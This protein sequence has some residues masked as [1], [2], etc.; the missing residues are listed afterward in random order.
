MA[1]ITPNK[2]LV[3]CVDLVGGRRKLAP[4]LVVRGASTGND[5]A[6]EFIDYMTA[7]EFRMIREQLGLSLSELARAL[8]ITSVRNVAQFEEGARPVSGPV[9]LIMEH[10]KAGDIKPQI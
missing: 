7:E 8:R 10:L 3:A 2:P 6:T 9:S 4:V 1:V 5:M